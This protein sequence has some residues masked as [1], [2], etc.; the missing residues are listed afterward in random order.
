MSID[1]LKNLFLHPPKKKMRNG[2][3]PLQKGQPN[4]GEVDR[5]SGPR[6]KIDLRYCSF[7]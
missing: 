3:F 6:L 1:I 2:K 5:G 4:E 7:A